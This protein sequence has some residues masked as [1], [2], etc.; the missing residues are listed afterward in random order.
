MTIEFA[1]AYIPLRMHELG[2][3]DQYT[4]RWRHLYLDA[5]ETKTIIANNEFYYLIQP[6][7]T[8]TVKSK[9]GMYDMKAQNISELLYEHRGHIVIKNTIATPQWVLFIQ[10]IPRHHPKE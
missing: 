4:I 10:A 1:I 3:Q 6:T 8:I 5:N 2:H 9:F 7:N